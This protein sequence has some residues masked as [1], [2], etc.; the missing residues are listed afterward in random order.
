M[1][2]LVTKTY[3]KIG[4]LEDLEFLRKTKRNCLICK[5]DIQKH[6]PHQED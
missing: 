2:E 5:G 6:I 4:S 3:M 1:G